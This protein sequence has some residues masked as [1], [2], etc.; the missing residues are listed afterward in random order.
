MDQ[1]YACALWSVLAADPLSNDEE[2]KTKFGAMAISHGLNTYLYP[3]RNAE[4]IAAAQFLHSWAD[5]L[6]GLK[7]TCKS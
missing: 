5:A 1:K 6:E 7:P 3:A 4:C 2:V